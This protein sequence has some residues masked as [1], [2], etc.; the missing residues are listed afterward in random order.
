[1]IVSKAYLIRFDREATDHFFQQ[2]DCFFD[3]PNSV[4]FVA[5]DIKVLQEDAGCSFNGFMKTP[6]DLT[7]CGVVFSVETDLGINR[8][9]LDTGST[10]SLFKSSQVE[11]NGRSFTTDKFQIGEADFGK[12]KFWL[13]E[14]SDR[15]EVDGVL[16]VDFF[17]K[18]AICLDFH[19]KIAYIKL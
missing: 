12:T 13:Y 14:F 7:H 16:G 15:L 19:N 5:K 1:M 6:F 4:M 9:L 17:K 18:H 8:F 10:W 11:K 3:F 2:M